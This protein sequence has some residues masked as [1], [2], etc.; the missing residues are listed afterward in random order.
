M[1]GS[2]ATVL[3]AALALAAGCGGSDDG[4]P[5]RDGGGEPVTLRLL[6]PTATQAGLEEMIEGFR[7]SPEGRDIRIDAEFVSTSDVQ[8]LL[9]TRLQA[10]NAPDLLFTYPGNGGANGVWPLAESGHLLEL[11]SQAVQDAVYEPTR[12]LVSQDGK[13][14]AL[15][16]TVTATGLLTNRALFEE[17]EL[18]PPESFE[19]LLAICEDLAA[20]GDTTA[21]AQGFGEAVLGIQIGQVLFGEFVYNIDPE[22]TEKRTS[23]EETFAGSQLWRRALQAL[24]DMKDA[25]C[26]PRGAAGMNREAQYAAFTEGEGVLQFGATTDVAAIG[27]IDPDLEITM[28]NLPADDPADT[29]TYTAANINTSVSADTEHPEEARAFIDYLADPAQLEKF[30]AA[31]QGIAPGDA[32]EGEVPD[33]MEEDAGERLASGKTVSAPHLAWPSALVF[34]DAYVNGLLGLM[35]EQTSVGDVLESMD[36]AWDRGG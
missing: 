4:D 6:M 26:F 2:V 36:R 11:P 13:I 12:E 34:N 24:V 27:A 32:E 10:N 31:S 19:D 17:L 30:A 15:P 16:N 25:G 20:S 18:K 7:S 29:A 33:F 28:M 3:A 22:W 23:G 8:Q 35:T 21:F 5:A 1:K 14:Y 9:L